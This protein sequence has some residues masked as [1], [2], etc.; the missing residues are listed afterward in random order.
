MEPKRLFRSRTNVMLGGVCGGLAEY[1]NVDATMIRL[2]FVLLFFLG[3][4][5]FLIYLVLWFITPVE[6]ASRPTAVE[7]VKTEKIDSVPSPVKTENEVQVQDSTPKLLDGEKKITR[8]TKKST[9]SAK[10]KNGK[11]G[12]LTPKADK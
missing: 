9:K 2:A 11:S 7:E 6:H 4:G 5:G 1:V 3:G 12:T 10:L 8:V